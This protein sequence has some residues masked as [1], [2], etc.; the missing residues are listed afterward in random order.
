LKRRMHSSTRALIVCSS[1]IATLPLSGLALDTRRLVKSG[2]LEACRNNPVRDMETRGPL[3]TC[4]VPMMRAI[5]YS[6]DSSLRGEVPVKGGTYQM[7]SPNGGRDERPVHGV[8]VSDFWMMKT[9]VTQ[10]DYSSLMGRN[11]SFF[12]GDDLPV[13]EVSWYDAIAYANALSRIDGLVPAYTV[14]GT[15]V[16]WNRGVSG[17][18]LPTEAEWEYAARGGQGSQGYTYA[19]GNDVDA[20]AW[21]IGNAGGK[22]HSVGSKAPNELGLFDMS[23]NVWEWCWDWW[24]SYPSGAQADPSGASSGTKRVY[25]GGSGGY[26]ASHARSS[27]RIG[28]TPD[29]RFSDLG[30]RLVRPLV[31]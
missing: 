11:P 31:R 25:R 6:F 4:V 27:D 22:T 17:W 8:T 21:Y 13:G 23:G 26:D 14:N 2:D 5:M 16:R 15:D 9:E 7:G 28:I 3:V 30:F 19:G 1:L 10:K 29:Y 18:R 20:V 12:K 24:G